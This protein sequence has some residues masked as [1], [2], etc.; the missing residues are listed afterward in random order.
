M[1]NQRRRR[2]GRRLLI[3]LVV[4]AALAGWFWWQQNGLVT[5]TYSVPNAPEALRG[6]RI[7]VVSDLHGK[8][9]GPDNAKLLD[10]VE[11][12]DPD[13]IALT[14]DLVDRIGTRDQLDRLPALAQSFCAI[15]P[16]YYVT[17]NHEW[18]AECVP[19]LK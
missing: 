12:L 5:V 13:C 18:A 16:T 2:H 8:E 11:D 14:G 6:Y 4:L 19:E 17:G 9:F 10:L 15:A 1:T 7:A 3:L